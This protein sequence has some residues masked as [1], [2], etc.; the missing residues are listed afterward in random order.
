MA[1]APKPPSSV[2]DLDAIDVEF[3]D[4]LSVD[5]LLEITGENWSI[6]AQV[7]SLK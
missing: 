4:P 7:E 2:T 3:D 5:K 6:D 1:E